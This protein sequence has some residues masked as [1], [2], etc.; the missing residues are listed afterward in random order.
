MRFS[1]DAHAIGQHLTGNETYVRNLLNCFAELD[2]EADF[3][4][5]L[6]KSEAF[7]EVPRRFLKRHVAV[8][9]FVRLGFDLPR[10]LRKDRPHLLHVQYTSPIF[11]STPIVVSVHDVSFIEHPGYFSPFRAIQLRCTV[12]R[13]V[14]SAARVLT[15]SK[16]SKQQILN[17]YQLHEDR[18]AVVPNGVA[19]AFHPIA[20][21]VAQRWVRSRFGWSSSF[22]L[23][24]GDL[25][26]R[27]NYIGLI[28]AFEKLM[29]AHPHLQQ[30]LVL[31]GKESWHASDIRVAARRSSVAD[32]IHFTGFVSDEELLRLYGA[33][34]LFVCPS[35]YEGF[36]LPILEAMACGRAVA[37]SNTSAMPEV[38]DSAA[39][40]F[41]PKSE[42]EIVLAMRDLLLNPEL[43]GRMERLGLQR[44]AT[45]SWE[46]TAA[47]TLDVYYAVAGETSRAAA[48]AVNAISAGQ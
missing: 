41:N 37:C 11:C 47:K 18:V 23:T 34:D 28:R 33:C 4:A 2:R 30:H 16:F 19:P 7:Q 36:G 3:V 32:R 42:D 45:F 8:D 31:V 5:Y 43:R 40:L 22:I 17:A 25:Q 46:S 35:F 24:V 15:A 1:V 48:P 29:R 27:K 26:P 21:E 14:K 44:A 20:R 10:K 9:P 12:R 6:S 38:A 13:T 39:I